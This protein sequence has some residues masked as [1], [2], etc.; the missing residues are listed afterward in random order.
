MMH[1]IV[2]YIPLLCISLQ[3]FAVNVFAE[4]FVHDMIAVRNEKTLLKAET[5]GR[6]YR[7]GGELVE[8]LVNGKSIGKTLSGGDGFVFKQFA[9]QKT[10]LHKITVKSATET[11]DGTL[12][13]LNKG[14][15]I[16][17][18]DVES[19][20]L[21]GG[22]FAKKPREGSQKAIKEINK[23]YPV[24]ILQTGFVSK[25]TIKEWLSKNG[26]PLLPVM[27]WGNGNI[28]DEFTEKGMK[29]IA[30]AGNN[31]II[32]SAAE[33]KPLSFSFTGKDGAIDVKNWDEIRKKLLKKK[34]KESR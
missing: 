3:F 15:G 12:L 16:F 26:Y 2:F 18:A 31:A 25:K 28:F 19:S 30:V 14:A 24:I 32:D 1:K 27:P 29:I 8:F 20:L 13:V 5:K 21:D 23:R 10:G 7:K 17:F 11:S 6:F 22:L 4:I 9:S 34:D 33:Y